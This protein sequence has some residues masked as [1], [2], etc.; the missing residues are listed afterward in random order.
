LKS[1]IQEKKEDIFA[2]K[3]KYGKKRSINGRRKSCKSIHV[4]R[5]APANAET[6]HAML[7]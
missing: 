1:Q 6:N 7:A 4:P 2:Q 5:R 3:E